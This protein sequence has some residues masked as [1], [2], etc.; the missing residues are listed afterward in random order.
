MKKFLKAKGLKF[1]KEREDIIREIENTEGHFDPDGLFIKMKNRGSKV[2]RASVYRTINLLLESGI[3]DVVEN[4]DRH[5]HYEKVKDKTHHDHMICIKC[6]KV[7]E[8]YSPTLEMLQQ[9]LC[10]KEGFTPTKHSLEIYGYCK[11]CYKK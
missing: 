7:I 10:E 4:I 6:G 9:E 11:Q 5:K 8:F 1:T 3:I 2:S